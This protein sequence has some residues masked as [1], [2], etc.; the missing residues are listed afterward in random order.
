MFAELAL[1]GNELARALFNTLRARRATRILLS[2]VAALLALLALLVAGLLSAPASAASAATPDLSMVTAPYVQGAIRSMSVWHSGGILIIPTVSDGTWY[3]RQDSPTPEPKPLDLGRVESMAEW[4]GSL[5]LSAEKGLFRWNAGEPAPQPVS[6]ITG[7]AFRFGHWDDRLLVYGDGLF[8]ISPN[9]EVARVGHDSY[10]WTFAEWKGKLWY[11]NLNGLFSIDTPQAQPRQFLPKAGGVEALINIGDTLYISTRGAGVQKLTDPAGPPSYL[12][13]SIGFFRSSVAWNGRALVATDDGVWDLNADPSAVLRVEDVW[14]G[15]QPWNGDILIGANA[16]LFRWTPGT[17]APEMVLDQRVEKLFDWDG[18]AMISTL[19]KGL[20]LWPKGV[21]A[22]QPF[23]LSIPAVDSFALWRGGL[24]MGL[25]DD[26]FLGSAERKGSLLVFNPADI[27]AGRIELTRP[28]AYL[29]GQPIYVTWRVEDSR[30]A[31]VPDFFHQKLDL[32]DEAGTVVRSIPITEHNRKGPNDFEANLPALAQDGA[33]RIAV[34]AQPPL[35]QPLQGKIALQIGNTSGARSFLGFHRPKDTADLVSMLAANGLAI[36][37]LYLLAVLALYV[38]R[39]AA[40]VSLHEA[41]SSERIPGGNIVAKFAVPLLVASERCLDAFVARHA[42]R[43]AAAFE[44]EPD[45]ATRP[46]WVPAPMRVEGELI[47][48]FHRPAELAADQSYVP[49]LFEIRRSLTKGSRIVVSIEGPGGVGKSALAFQIARWAVSGLASA[50]LAPHRMLP[51]LI[52][53]PGK[54]LDAAVANQLSYVLDVPRLSSRLLEAVLRQC[55]IIAVVDGLSEMPDEAATLGVQPESGARNTHAIIVTSRLSVPIPGALRINPQGLTLRYLDG[56][57][58]ELISRTLGAG[59]FSDV[60]RET[61]RTRLK[62]LIQ[63]LA[64]PGETSPEI[65]MLAVVLMLRR[66][67]DLAVDETS[68]LAPLPSGFADLVLDYGAA[69]LHDDLA[70]MTAARAAA[71]VCSGPDFAPSWRSA[72]AYAAEGITAAQ[73]KAFVDTGL[74]LKHGA[75]DD[76]Q[77]KFAL[78]PVA[79]SLA[80]REYLIRMRDGRLSRQAFGRQLRKAGESGEA[81]EKTLKNIVDIA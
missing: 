71:V 37:V 48:D 62:G 29:A 17:D 80:A 41:L 3:W 18:T 77:Y 34:V 6:G 81:F 12:G 15:F 68:D 73:L 55:R 25:D 35:G 69:L 56:V 79:E 74:L 4:N 67:N 19:E 76:P 22:P 9:G 27:G 60:Q 31:A 61:I 33:Y 52:D 38:L 21:A 23:P 49:G 46:T 47:G 16:G 30:F 51:L 44:K 63:D 40:L 70:L 66:A 13:P 45:I 24:V 54:D 14:G 32:L 8:V 7:H 58:D 10:F 11:G 53:S 20:W 59:R 36:A 28:A 39:P 72:G 50:R 57:L 26:S 2:G 42:D 64:A 5:Y 75:S 65:P 78:D 43:V 1:W